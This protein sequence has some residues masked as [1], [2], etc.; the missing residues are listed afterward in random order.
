EE[1]HRPGVRITPVLGCLVRPAAA[2]DRTGL[3]ERLVEVVLVGPDGL[4]AGLVVVAPGAAEDP[5]VQPLA[6]FAEALPRPVVRPHEIAVERGRDS[7][8]DL[9]HRRIFPQR[10]RRCVATSS[11]READTVAP[12]SS[13]RT[14]AV[15]R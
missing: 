7:G 4:P 13:A 14:S 3:A 12:A 11:P 10:R 5:G 2:D 15:P 8:G 6:A 1:R 9:G